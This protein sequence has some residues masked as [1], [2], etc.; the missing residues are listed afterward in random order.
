MA[1]LNPGRTAVATLQRGARRDPR[2]PGSRPLQIASLPL[3]TAK[4]TL[5]LQPKSANP[6]YR[7]VNV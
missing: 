7:Y 4:V 6:K 3:D 2:N 5:Q 1:L